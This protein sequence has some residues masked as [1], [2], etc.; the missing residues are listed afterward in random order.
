MHL[1][2]P[3]YN[4]YLNPKESVSLTLLLIVQGVN[5]MQMKLANQ[6]VTA[7]KRKHLAFTPKDYNSADKTKITLRT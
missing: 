4:I 1:R 2:S 7:H 3:T 5:K 6:F